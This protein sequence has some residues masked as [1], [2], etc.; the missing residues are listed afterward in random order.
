[1]SVSVRMEYIFFL[2]YLIQQNHYIRVRLVCVQNS[3]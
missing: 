2:A 3:F 1:M